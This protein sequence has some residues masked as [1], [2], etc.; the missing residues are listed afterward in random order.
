MVNI[1]ILED[2]KYTREF[3]KKL[4]SE[5]PLVD[6]V[7]A[8]ESGK[9]AISIAEEEVIHVALFDIEL[10]ESESL[11]GLDIAKNIHLINPSIKMI[12]VTGYAKY[13]IDSFSVH[14][15]DYILKPINRK[16][17]METIHELASKE[18]KQRQQKMIVRNRNETIFIPFDEII[19]I[20]KHTNHIFINTADSKYIDNSTL[21]EIE[22][23]LPNDFLRVHKSYI[24]NMKKIKKILEVGNRSYQIH[25]IHSNKVAYM[26]R[27]K[28]FE[29]KE[30]FIPSI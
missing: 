24:V 14:P 17:L 2:E 7:F 28:Y 9:E 13:A 1:L 25:F 23:I 22:E 29:L 11:N 12:F 15:Y 26:S 5:S 18:M 27:Y 19:F 16:K 4:V 20:E 8:T 30:Y 6:Q 10:E 3:I 21:G